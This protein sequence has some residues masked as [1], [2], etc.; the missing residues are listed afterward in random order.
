MNICLTTYRG[1]PYCGGQGIYITYLARELARLGHSVHTVSGPPY[2]DD[3]PGVTCHRLPGVHLNGDATQFPSEG[4][5]FAA[6]LPVNFYAWAASLT[7]LRK[8]IIR[9]STLLRTAFGVMPSNSAALDMSK[10]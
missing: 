1:N 5:P 4:K 9:R 6:F 10:T 8:G 3:I 2:P 7:G